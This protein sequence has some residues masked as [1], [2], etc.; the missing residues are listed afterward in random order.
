MTFGARNGKLWQPTNCQDSKLAFKF[1][2][3]PKTCWLQLCSCKLLNIW[4][5]WFW[6]A[7]LGLDIRCTLLEKRSAL[8][9]V[10]MSRC[11]KNVSYSW[12]FHHVRILHLM[13]PNIWECE[14]DFNRIL[15]IFR[16]INQYNFSTVQTFELF[17][18]QK[19]YRFPKHDRRKL[20]LAFLDSFSV[21]HFKVLLSLLVRNSI[22]TG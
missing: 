16:H 14:K 10:E 9:G 12:T 19:Y 1:F 6:E 15:F 11:Q 17:E 22:L 4:Q 13:L 5:F 3:P 18:G 20:L 2:L 7:F 8:K 21:F